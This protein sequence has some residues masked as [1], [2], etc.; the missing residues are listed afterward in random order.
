MICKKCT[1][2]GAIEG[3]REISLKKC[4]VCK[5]QFPSRFLNVCSECQLLHKHCLACG[6]LISE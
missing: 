2:T 5:K 6:K 3:S 1:K 4:K